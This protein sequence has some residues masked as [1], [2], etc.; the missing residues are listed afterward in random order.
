M[1]RSAS[2]LAGAVLGLAAAALIAPQVVAQQVAA[3][4]NAA[5]PAK[6]GLGRVALPEEIKA[7]DT[8]VR[9]DGQGLP[10]GKGTVKQGDALFQAHCA[11]CHGE[12]GEGVGRWP[13]LAG[14]HGTLKADRPDKT[15]G[16][17]WPDLS[18]V[19][20]Y[21]RRAMPFGNAHSLQNDEIYAIVAYLL[22]MNDIVK[23]E[24]FELNERNFTSI[25]MPNAGAFYE[26]DR[27]IAEKHFWKKDP[28]M[29]NCRTTA[30]KVTGRAIN[31]DVTPDSKAGPKVD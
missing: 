27:E 30:P 7:W 16:S 6:L 25:K 22:A 24:N 5:P 20:D 17:F 28:C 10:V 2:V 19:F 3:R 29:K 18:S 12:F 23:D 4:Q 26:D 13:V 1:S 31:V 9:P 15:I 11:T 14:G 21:I 8:D